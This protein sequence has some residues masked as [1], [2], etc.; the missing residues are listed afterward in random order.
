MRWRGGRRSDNIEDRRGKRGP[1]AAGGIGIV[2]IIIALVIA[3]I[4]NGGKLGIGDVA[5]V[6]QNNKQPR[7]AAVQGEEREL[8][9][10]EKEMGQFL[11]VVL[12]DTEDVWTK[13]FAQSGQKYQRPKLVIFD[14]QVVESGCGRVPSGAGP[15]YCPADSKLYINPQFYDDL[16]KKLGAPGDFARAYVI[17]HEVGHHI[18]NL[19]G[20]SDKVRRAQQGKSK[21]EANRYSVMLEL[22]ADFYAGVWAHH[23]QKMRNVI[24]SGDIEEALN[25]AAAIGDDTL[26]KNARGY[27]KPE[28]FTHG[29]S[30]ERVQWFTLGLET[31]DVR[32][33]DTFKAMQ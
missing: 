5:K 17:A 1:A 13:I 14:S 26:Q 28:T 23:A 30:K 29:T 25:A 8:T 20:T 22:Q 12:A 3:Y 2:G 27:V 32:K 21:A 11:S 33:G 31:G 9:K 19:L 7:Q 6:I 15:F 16:K 10:A 18:Q 24:E 4:S